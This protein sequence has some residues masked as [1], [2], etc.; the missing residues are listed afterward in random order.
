[1][2]LQTWKNS[3]QGKILRSNV[4]VARNYLIEKE[5]KTLERIVS[6]YLD[7]A[8]LQATRQIPM[9]RKDWIQKLDAFLKFNEYEVLTDVG[10]VSHEVAVKLA[11]EEYER[12]RVMQDREYVG[13]F[14]KEVKRITSK[15]RRGKDKQSGGQSSP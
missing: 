3:P 5:I 15:Q 4:T 13:D 12:F 2:G 14:E 6:M 8:E 11:G 10:R 1:M 9:K 7:Y